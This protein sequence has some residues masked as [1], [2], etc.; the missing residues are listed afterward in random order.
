MSWEKGMMM[1]VREE[2]EKFRKGNVKRKRLE[3]E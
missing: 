1:V 2:I 3:K